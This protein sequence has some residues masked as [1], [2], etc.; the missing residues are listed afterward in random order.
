MSQQPPDEQCVELGANAQVRLSVITFRASHRAA[1]QLSLFMRP[2][3][4]ADLTRR[5]SIRIPVDRVP[6]LVRILE[7]L[8]GMADVWARPPGELRR[9][10]RE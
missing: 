8:A 2:S 1:V 9:E 3:P 6:Q 10:V 5:S 4:W 7:E